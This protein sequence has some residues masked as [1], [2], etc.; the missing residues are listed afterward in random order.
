[1]ADLSNEY[2]FAPGMQSVSDNRKAGNPTFAI[3]VGA[4]PY[5][6]TA[7]YP[8]AVAVTGGT[9]SLLT[10]KRGGVSVGLGITGGL[11]EL[12]TGDSLTTTWAVSAPTLTAIPR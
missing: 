3:A 1:M 12:N 5:T 8:M 6:Y 7:P 9:V 11:I 2:T 10:Y 4:S